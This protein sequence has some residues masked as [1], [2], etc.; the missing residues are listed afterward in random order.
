M[1]SGASGNVLLT[2]CILMANMNLIELF[3][4]T[5]KAV[6]GGAIWLGFRVAANYIST[7]QKKK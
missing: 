7:K 1:F 6:I 5:V 2:T 3:D 4:Y